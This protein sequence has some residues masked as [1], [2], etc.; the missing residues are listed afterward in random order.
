MLFVSKLNFF[1]LIFRPQFRVFIGNPGAGKSTLA[2]CVANKLLFES[3]VRYRR[4]MTYQLDSKSHDG[5]TYLETPGLSDIVLRKKAAKAI[6]E[7]L[8][9]NGT[10]QVFFVI[11]LEAGRLRPDD[12]TTIKLVLESASDIKHYSL[13]INKLSTVVYDGLLEND[14]EQ[15]KFMITELVLQTNSKDK[16]PTVFLQKHSVKLWD[17]KNKFEELVDLK[18]FV[19][20]APSMNVRPTN[21]EDIKGVDNYEEIVKIMSQKLTKLR[22]NKE[23]LVREKKE[24]EKKYREILTRH[25]DDTLDPARQGRTRRQTKSINTENEFTL[26]YESFHK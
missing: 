2:N 1:I 12:I 10:Y 25:L 3:G 11:T 7:A 4:G 8:K 23:V 5:I 13:I 19:D 20:M 22:K 21:I 16:P 18:E 17:G 24:L 15:L 14:A 6:T 26:K 9:Q